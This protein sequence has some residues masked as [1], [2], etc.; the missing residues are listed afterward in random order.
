M[1]SKPVVPMIIALWCLMLS[2]RASTAQAT[3]DTVLE[4]KSGLTPTEAVDFEA[5]R[6]SVRPFR[7]AAFKSMSSTSGTD[8][9]YD[10][11]QN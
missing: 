6:Q 4:Y 2:V 3:L 7:R 9:R 8:R 11:T 5:M 10:A 1:G